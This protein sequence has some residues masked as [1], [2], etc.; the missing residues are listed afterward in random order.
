MDMLENSDFFFSVTGVELRLTLRIYSLFIG[1]CLEGI[2]HRFKTSNIQYPSR[3]TLALSR[4]SLFG[5]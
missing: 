4:L 2:V 1:V 5:S 3:V